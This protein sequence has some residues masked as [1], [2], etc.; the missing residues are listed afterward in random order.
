[1]P[2]DLS[3][4]KLALI[5]VVS[6]LVFGPGKTVEF[7]REA[8]KWVRELRRMWARF[9]EDISLQ[10]LLAAEPAGAAA[11]AGEPRLTCPTCGADNISGS[12]YCARC[13]AAL[14]P[15]ENVC[16]ACGSRNVS[17]KTECGLCGT[18]LP[19]ASRAA[20]QGAGGGPTRGER[21]EV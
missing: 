19:A 4:E 8:G 11:A 20:S 2:F 3:I 9:A 7:A 1:M 6:L 12:L 5:L 17:E 10:E 16:P 14:A 18:R 15:P 21:S 13:G